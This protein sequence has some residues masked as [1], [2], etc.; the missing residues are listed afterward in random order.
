MA[1]SGFEMPCY[2][3][4]EGFRA[5]GGGLTFNPKQGYVDQPLAVPCGQCIGC[6]LERSRQWAVRC[7][8]EASLHLYNCFLTLTY[9]EKNLPPDLS[10][11]KRVVQLFIKRLRKHFAGVDIRY[12]AAG[13]YGDTTGRPHYHVIVFGID[14]ADKNWVKSSKGG[15]LYRSPTLD[16]LWGLGNAWIGSVTFQSAAYVA[17]YCTKKITG[18][19][20]ESHY[21]GRQPEFSLSSNRPAIGARYAARYLSESI[22]HDS[23]IGNAVEQKPPRYYDKVAKRQAFDDFKQIKQTRRLDAVEPK[24][25]QN[26]T[27][28]RLAVREEIATAKLNLKRSTL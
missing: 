27:P 24:A 1:V 3:P 7:Q 6:K 8:H 12:Y 4:R 18:Q 5:V 22:A 25:R 19:A 14:F 13:E 23:V 15:D 26:A 16:R 11:D 2:H 28:P 20:A 10:V 17:R 9:D 21:G